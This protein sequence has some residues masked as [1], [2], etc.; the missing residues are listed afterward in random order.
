MLVEL[1]KL[2]F[3][4]GP[5]K[6]ALTKLNKEVESDSEI[7]KGLADWVYYTNRM[8]HLEYECK[9]NILIEQNN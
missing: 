8:T 3:L 5:L 1:L 9:K 6:R 2:N 4:I 7:Q